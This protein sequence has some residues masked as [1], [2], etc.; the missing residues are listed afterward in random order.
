MPYK[1][2][3]VTRLSFSSM[4]DGK[5]GVRV[6]ARLPSSRLLACTPFRPS[7]M[8]SM[9]AAA[10]PTGP[11]DTAAGIPNPPCRWGV[12]ILSAAS[13]HASRSRWAVSSV[14]HLLPWPMRI[15]SVSRIFSSK[16]RKKGRVF[17]VASSPRLRKSLIGFR[18]ARVSWSAVWLCAGA[19]SST[20][21]SIFSKASSCF[22]SRNR[23]TNAGSPMGIPTQTHTER[24]WCTQGP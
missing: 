10:L 13:R 18:H 8:Q 6:G 16:R 15:A 5:S 1:L 14:G 12:L 9:T 24:Q 2:P 7:L 19:N 21:R 4:Q 11:F 17:V 23:L 22:S 3:L 20:V